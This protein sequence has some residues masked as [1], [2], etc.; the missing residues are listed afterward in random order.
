V[1]HASSELHT[2]RSLLS[3]VALLII[4]VGA[5]SALTL[6]VGRQEGHQ[7]VKTER[8]D[9]GVVVSGSRCRFAY[10]PA[11]AT[12]T[13]SC[14]SKSRLVLPSWWYRSGVRSPG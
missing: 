8:W 10:G 12:A 3:M 2:Q 13:I 9:T 7:P 1:L 14:S 5:F 11:D 4:V 6:L